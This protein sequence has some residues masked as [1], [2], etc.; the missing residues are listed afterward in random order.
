MRKGKGKG[1][2]VALILLMGSCGEGLDLET[3]ELE[4]SNQAISAKPVVG[5]T[6]LDGVWKCLIHNG[7]WIKIACEEKI[8][9]SNAKLAL[10][11]GKI[12]QLR[13]YAMGGTV[14]IDGES[15][16]ITKIPSGFVRANLKL[17]LGKADCLTISF[18]FQADYA[19]A[20]KATQIKPV[21]NLLSNEASCEVTEKSEPKIE[22]IP[23]KGEM[24]SS[25]VHHI[26]GHTYVKDAIL[27]KLG[28][29]VAVGY[30]MTGNGYEDKVYAMQ[31][32]ADGTRDAS[33]GGDGVINLAVMPSQYGSN[34]AFAIVED[35]TGYWI[36]GR[37]Q[38]IVHASGR[39]LDAFWLH[40]T[41]NGTPDKQTQVLDLGASES[42]HDITM[43]NQG[44]LVMVGS[45]GDKYAKSLILRALPDGNLDSAFG[46]GGKIIEDFSPVLGAYPGSV[47]LDNETIIVSG[48]YM[49]SD[50]SNRAY[51]AKYNSS[52]IIDSVYGLMI[53]AEPMDF[54]EMKA[55]NGRPV[56]AGHKKGVVKGSTIYGLEVGGSIPSLLSD[57]DLTNAFSLALQPDGKFLIAGEIFNANRDIV[58]FRWNEDG[59]LDTSFGSNG[60]VITDLGADDYTVRLL[61]KPDGSLISVGFTSLG[62]IASIAIVNYR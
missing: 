62:G 52:G 35:D 20:K 6:I 40:I 51:A 28:K 5:N 60:K 7:K 15:K 57:V 2:V 14:I 49:A 21:L 19:L 41:W 31:L 13:F 29:I 17:N 25:Q 44:R 10:P 27:T 38:G 26:M 4:Q 55:K 61:V 16:A 54:A 58:I 56:W 32:N 42:I 12:T 24:A 18:G 39:S 48:R 45:A 59:S 30:Y 8:D 23:A 43:D 37:I 3:L 11:T 47:A 9:L 53:S 22:F 34:T 36:A 46:D 50:Q 1:I 33:F